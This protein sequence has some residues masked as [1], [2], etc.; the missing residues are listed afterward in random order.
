MAGKVDLTRLDTAAVWETLRSWYHPDA[1]DAADEGPGCGCAR[2][3]AGPGRRTT[4]G[5]WPAALKNLTS[6]LIG[7]FC[8]RCSRRPSP[9]RR[10][11]PPAA[12]WV[13]PGRRGAEITALK[14]IAAHY[15]MQTPPGWRCRS[16]SASAGGAGRGPA[17]HRGDGPRRGLR[18]GLEA[19]GGR[20]RD[21][22][23]DRPGRPLTDA[24]AVAWH[25]CLVGAGSPTFERSELT[26][27]NPR[28]AGRLPATVRRR[29]SW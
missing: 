27:R 28:V 15:V 10:A 19:G 24:S 13:V 8:G 20:C 2:W 26:G 7:R 21:P 18:G 12:P 16:G 11:C 1:T 22:G 23:R 29:V 5:K 14:S 3:A 25:R 6:D 9:P 17:A 4:G